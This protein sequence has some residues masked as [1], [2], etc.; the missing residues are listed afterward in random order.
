MNDMQILIENVRKSVTSPELVSPD[1][2][3]TYAHQYADACKELNRRMMLCVQQ[4]RAGNITE[5]IRLS[6]LKPNLT[7]LYLSL[8]IPER[9]EWDEIVSTLGF[10]VSQPLPVEMFREIGDAYLKLSPLE[11]LMRWHRLHALNGSPLRERL[12]IIRSLAKKDQENI[13]W[14]EDQEKF[15]KARIRELEKEVQHAIATKNQEQIRSL[16][17]ELS[18][19]GWIHPPPPVL[20][21]KLA[22]S[23]LQDYADLLMEK[24]SVFDYEG[25]MGVHSTIQQILTAEKMDMPAAIRKQIRPAIQW[26]DDTQ[27]RKTLLQEFH[28]AVAGLQE[29]LRYDTPLPELERQ[30]YVVAS[31]ATQA[32]MDI[33]VEL[34]EHYQADVRRLLTAA[35]RKN[36]LAVL[37]ILAVCVFIGV[38]I[39]W[40][41]ERGKYLHLLAN[42]ID[43]IERIVK[44]ERYDDIQNKLDEIEKLHQ[45][46][47]HPD[48]VAG[49][50]H[51]KDLLKTAVKGSEEFKRSHAQA[52]ESLRLLKPPNL[53]DDLKEQF[54]SLKEIKRLIDQAENL[55]RTEQEEKS[56]VELKREYDIAYSIRVHEIDKIFRE[57]LSKLSEERKILD[58][59]G[60]PSEE[61]KGVL[62]GLNAIDMRLTRLLIDSE[63]ISD[64]MKRLAD[65]ERNWIKGLRLRV[66]KELEKHGAKE[67]LF[68]TVGDW[69]KYQ[70]ALQEITSKFPNDPIAND[71]ND[72]L[73]ELDTVMEVA[74]LLNDFVVSFTKA[75]DDFRMLRQDSTSLKNKYEN[76]TAKISGTPNDI[77]QLQDDLDTLSKMRP[78]THGT[79]ATVVPLLT[80]PAQNDIE[81]YPWVDGNKWYYLT[82]KPSRAGTYQYVTSFL[83]D[84][85]TDYTIPRNQFSDAKVPVTTQK[86]FAGT[87]QRRITGINDDA[88][89]VVHAIM[90]DL[91]KRENEEPGIDPILQCFMM[92]SLIR[93]MSAIDP[94]FASNFETLRTN[95]QRQSIDPLANWMDVESPMST[96]DQRGKAKTAIDS[97]SPVLPTIQSLFDKTRQER[98]AFMAKL[99]QLRLSFAWVGVLSRTDGQ[100]E[101]TKADSF[102]SESGDLCILRP[103]VNQTVELVRIGQVTSGRFEMAG[104]VLSLRLLQYTPVFLVHR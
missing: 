26:I 75:G 87:A 61:M 80:K 9:E 100:W 63:G 49:V 83:G 67:K 30:Y 10:E 11:P 37:L 76:A 60:L 22:E 21:W 65:A 28:R 33:P 14:S 101:V 104:N 6:E 59:T 53:P 89:T 32:G 50:N 20:R 68:A 96:A 77:F 36:Q 12:A 46:R 17:A 23:S 41:H 64:S 3:Q 48:V 24:F 73:E 92:D 45:I 4:I 79:F 1:R 82:T 5:G 95:I 70:S 94:F 8:D 91:F 7:E 15:E 71:G 19:T 40:L 74:G 56:F 62:H 51:L 35:R 72:V 44:E 18:D 98:T 47:T 16:H 27:R 90:S 39:Y 34:E 81:L 97:F 13:F 86:D 29:V 84:E 85:K 88:E 78:Y 99:G 43:S 69:G 93:D 57:S 58:K 31:A 25:A 52:S 55:K 103:N 102:D 54:S 38:V 42:T 2:M 66:E